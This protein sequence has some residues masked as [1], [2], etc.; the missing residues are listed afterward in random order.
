[1]SGEWQRARWDARAPATERAGNTQGH[2]Y[3]TAP[4]IGSTL[5]FVV[6]FGLLFPFGSLF[7]SMSQIAALSYR[8]LS[9]GRLA[10]IFIVSMLTRMTRWSRSMM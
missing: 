3:T 5:W 4:L 2:T 6:P 7:P 8:S 10:T 9:A 1:M